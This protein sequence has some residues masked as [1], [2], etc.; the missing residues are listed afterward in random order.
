MVELSSR[1]SLYG[2]TVVVIWRHKRYPHVSPRIL[3][4]SRPTLLNAIFHLGLAIE[5]ITTATIAT[6]DL[7]LANLGLFPK[8]AFDSPPDDVDLT[9]ISIDSAHHEGPYNTL[10]SIGSHPPPPPVLT[11]LPTV[12]GHCN[13]PHPFRPSIVEPCGLHECYTAPCGWQRSPP[14]GLCKCYTAPCTQKLPPH[15]GLRE[16][17]TTRVGLDRAI[18]LAPAV[19]GLRDQCHHRR[20]CFC[21][22]VIRL[23]R[24]VFQ[25]NPGFA[26]ILSPQCRQS[27]ERLICAWFLVFNRF[28]SPPPLIE[29]RQ[30]SF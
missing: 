30:H 23:K 11:L 10:I 20:T 19:A 3:L 25:L 7:H 15:C 24:H 16:Y 9:N 17:G 21:I 12:L 14:C 6:V 2:L 5:I 27:I 22:M 26:R 18:K 28:I 13:A 8:T 29:L 4:S 1:R